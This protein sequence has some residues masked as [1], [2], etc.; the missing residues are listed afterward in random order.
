MPCHGDHLQWA[1]AAQIS[2]HA[3]YHAKRPFAHFATQLTA[4][5]TRPAVG[6]RQL[7]GCGAGC[8]SSRPKIGQMVFKVPPAS[9][10]APASAEPPCS[11]TAAM[12][13]KRPC[14]NPALRLTFN[15]VRHSPE[16]R[17]R[18]IALWVGQTRLN[19]TTSG[20]SWAPYATAVQFLSA[21][22]Y[23]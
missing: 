11:R 23:S 21:Q 17:R 8:N 2:R 7:A 10:T 19:Q 16:E 3:Q 9:L 20:W 15:P 22:P 4:S 6:Q 5:K 18:N 1:R 12:P 14:P 13:R